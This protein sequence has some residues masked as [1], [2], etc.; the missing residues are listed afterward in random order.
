MRKAL[1]LALVVLGLNSILGQI[2]VI[3]ELMV[4]FY[5]NELSAGIILAAW[6][7]WTAIGSGVLSKGVDNWG[8]PHGGKPQ[9]GL[10]A[11]HI[12]AALALPGMIW[13]IR[14]IRKISGLFP[15]EIIGLGAMLYSSL[16]ILAPLGL[17]LG[18]MFSLGCR[19]YAK[20]TGEEAASIGRIYLYEAIGASLGG[21][22]FTY[23]LVFWATHLQIALGL[24]VLN[25]LCAI[26]ILAKSA[27]TSKSIILILSALALSLLFS[28][29]SGRAALGDK[30]LRQLSWPGVSVLASEDSIYGNL[31]ATTDKGQ[32]SLFANGLL[33]FS[34]PDRLSAEEAVHF[35]LLEHPHPQ[36][37]LLIGGGI[38][39]ALAEVLKHP[40]IAKVDYVELDP[41]IISMGKQILPAA[42]WA[43]LS[44]PRVKIAHI[45]GRRW[46]SQTN[47]IYD[48]I[49]VN[50]PEPSTAQLNRFYTLEFF[51]AAH[52]ILSP[53][54][55][56][57]TS[58]A[59]SEN[60]ISPELAQFLASIYYT[61][62]RVFAEVIALPGGT[63]FIMGCRQ[64][65]ILTADAAAL[66]SRLSE[67]QLDTQYVR[68]YYIPYRLSGERV[69]YLK[70][71]LSKQTDVKINTDFSPV[72]Y[73][74][75]MLL[76][77]NNFSPRFRGLFAWFSRLRLIHWLGLMLLSGLAFMGPKLFRG[78][79][80][81]GRQAVLFSVMS[82]GFAEITFEIVVILAF[83]IMFG[84]VYYKLGIILAGFM[85]GL[86]LGSYF[87]TRWLERFSDPY[88]AFTI[89]QALVVLYPLLL[90]G[91]FWAGS[92]LLISG[93][94][95]LWLEQLFPLLT[96]IAGAV[97]GFQFPLA[98]KLYLGSGRGVGRSAG[99]TYG[100]DLTGSCLGA[101][102][103]SALLLPVL[104]VFYTCIA[105]CLLNMLA[106][107][108][109]FAG[110]GTKSP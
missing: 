21:V 45:D 60:Y 63:N 102:I 52:R 84:Y 68:E 101:A 17:S 55:I 44:D 85:I 22:L 97:G 108:F 86:V 13:G 19:L 43:A 36:K 88:R 10:I 47:E 89:V 35:P 93:R 8:E 7:F 20:A 1:I 34:Y 40:S 37:V 41:S 80:E 96:I 54:G 76:W 107:I 57:C 18:L 2:I 78:R 70:R 69:E 33:M 99:V 74:Y 9:Q 48:L 109:L 104:G 75:N 28:L 16:L 67:R 95:N 92:R 71:V 53:Q 105:V 6:L 91:I 103:S 49:L 79:A 62:E 25:I 66:V 58:F 31:T 90:I 106:L 39:G 11:C 100:M 73:Y 77:V 26:F 87:S 94:Y 3:R 59:S 14:S 50:L 38:G 23:C 24:A 82:T 51:L 72:S 64:S 15:G 81:L 12:M 32:Q 46:V 98:N 5:G 4:V 29:V 27:P 83:Q 61:M 110:K 56:I 30:Y 65:G 42:A